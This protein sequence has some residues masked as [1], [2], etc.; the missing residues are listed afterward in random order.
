MKSGVLL[1]VN[2]PETPVWASL[3]SGTYPLEISL[4]TTLE[5]IACFSS[6]FMVINSYSF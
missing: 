3:Y 5:Y 1:G 2:K 4:W 6:F